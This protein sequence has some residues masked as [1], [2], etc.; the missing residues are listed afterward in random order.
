MSYQIRCK[1][2]VDFNFQ[3]DTPL[4][5][6]GHILRRHAYFS[7]SHTDKENQTYKEI[8]RKILPKISFFNEEVKR[9]NADIR[10]LGEMDPWVN[11]ATRKDIWNAY[12]LDNRIFGLGV[13]S[14][15]FFHG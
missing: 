1:C 14:F 6:I 2:G 9:Y 4:E 5:S 15:K 12:L 13:W 7:K 3:R 8:V 11:S 10:E